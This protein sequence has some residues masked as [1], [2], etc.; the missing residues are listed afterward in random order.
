MC[1]QAVGG[2]VRRGRPGDL[3]QEGV[4]LEQHLQLS[5]VTEVTQGQRSV[6]QHRACGHNQG[7]LVDTTGSPF[8]W[9]LNWLDYS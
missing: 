3:S 4:E 5:D 9:S 6:G 7:H 1:Q 2:V 8:R